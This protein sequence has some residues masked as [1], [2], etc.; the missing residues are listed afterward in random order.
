MSPPFMSRSR[1]TPSRVT[2]S[3]PRVSAAWAVLR[4]HSRVARRPNQNVSP[5]ATASPAARNSA[6][7][8]RAF[9]ESSLMATVPFDRLSAQ[10]LAFPVVARRAGMQ[11]NRRGRSA[12]DV[13][14]GGRRMRLAQDRH[15][16]EERAGQVVHERLRE[17]LP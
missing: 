13:D 17:I 9:A 2:T 4:S 3:L 5:V 1:A 10:D 15:R 6:R 14:T 16:F 8:A 11:R 12:L 7:L